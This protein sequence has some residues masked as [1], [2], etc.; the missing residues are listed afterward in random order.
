MCTWNPQHTSEEWTAVQQPDGISWKGFPD[1]RFRSN[2]LKI[3]QEWWGH[4]RISSYG[5]ILSHDQNLNTPDGQ[6]HVYP[7]GGDKTRK[8]QV[9][10]MNQH[11]LWKCFILNVWCC[12]EK[13]MKMAVT[14]YP[15]FK[16]YF[17]W[18]VCFSY[19]LVK[20]GHVSLKTVCGNTVQ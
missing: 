2:V 6:R 19:G 1:T 10:V 15:T 20:G 4:P 14:G 3:F 17:P 8:T 12:H 11:L 16:R 7:T 18:C 13:K 9:C 5:F